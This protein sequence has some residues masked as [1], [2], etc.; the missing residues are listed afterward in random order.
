MKFAVMSMSYPC[1]CVFN[2]AVQVVPQKCLSK[3][4]FNRM[5]ST[6]KASLVLSYEEA[7]VATARSSKSCHRFKL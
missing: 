4:F 2:S 7:G 5:S 3:G 6:V 1:F